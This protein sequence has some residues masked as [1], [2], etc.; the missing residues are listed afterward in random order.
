MLA[1]ALAERSARAEHAVHP[2]VT[3]TVF[4]VAWSGGLEDPT[5]Q[6]FIDAAA[7]QQQ[8]DAWVA[9]AHDRYDRVSLV[10]QD[11]FADGTVL[12]AKVDEFC[13]AWPESTD[14]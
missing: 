7:A 3:M 2:G 5:F 13:P 1:Q 6:S 4:V 8:F 10:R 9:D 14:A 11:I 12:T